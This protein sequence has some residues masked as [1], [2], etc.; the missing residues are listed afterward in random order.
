V[1]WNSTGI[2]VLGAYG[3]AGT[4][5]NH[6][7]FPIGI[8][9]DSSNTMYVADGD[10]NRVQK[11]LW[12]NTAATTVAGNSGGTS[13]STASLLSYPNDV[14]VDSNGSMYVVDTTNNRVQLWYVNASVGI[15]IAGNSKL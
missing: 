15:T 10:N 1:H 3:N 6:L 8:V 11:L 2:S 7:N 5:S 12:N 9:F 4:A 13:G 14:A